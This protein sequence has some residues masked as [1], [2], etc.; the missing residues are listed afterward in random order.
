MRREVT[1]AF[2]IIMS[3]VADGKTSITRVV[4]IVETV[5]AM[6]AARAERGR[7]R[8]LSMP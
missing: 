4:N 6:V 7:A 1:L 8:C 5:H 3:L 2:V